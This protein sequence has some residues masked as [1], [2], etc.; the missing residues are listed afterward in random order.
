MTSGYTGISNG[1]VIYT[2][3]AYA[4]KPTRT[5]TI[6]IGGQTFTV[7]QQGAKNVRK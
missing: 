2:V 6:T 5:G 4:S 1:T 3:D 7:T